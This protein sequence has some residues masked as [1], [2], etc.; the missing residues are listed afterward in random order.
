MTLRALP[1]TSTY[2]ISFQPLCMPCMWIFHEL[3]SSA[4]YLKRAVDAMNGCELKVCS[5]QQIFQ[6]VKVNKSY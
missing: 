5:A 3:R 1:A 6:G 2:F 4:F